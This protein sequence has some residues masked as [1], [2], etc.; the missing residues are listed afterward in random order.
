MK[1]RFIACVFC[2]GF[3]TA[4]YA[5]GPGKDKMTKYNINV[6]GCMASSVT[7]GWNLDSLFGEP[8]VKGEYI[9]YG[10]SNCKPHYSTVLW[11][12]LVQRNGQG[13]GYVRV[14]PAVPRAGSVSYDTAGSPNWD[15]LVCG[16]S[17]TK[18]N[19]CFNASDAKTMWKTAYVADFFFQYTS[20]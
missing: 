15:S 7:A 10:D 4:S 1:Y 20:N 12:K 18:K 5:V 11:L 2:L 19:G 6:G 17:G 3:M 14:S 9:W 16:Q 8:T 13:S